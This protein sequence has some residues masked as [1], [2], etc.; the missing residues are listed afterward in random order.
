MG[1]PPSLLKCNRDPVTYL[2]LTE[3]RKQTYE[4]H[5]FKIE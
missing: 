1:D 5:W 3:L 4:K 2:K